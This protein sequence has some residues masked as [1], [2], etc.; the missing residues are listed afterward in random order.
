MILSLDIICSSKFLEAH[1][2]EQIVSADKFPSVFLCQME[3]IIYLL[4]HQMEA[5]VYLYTDIEENKI[6]K[7]LKL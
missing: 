6:L 4:L 3:A 1:F 7:Y 5:F 2:V